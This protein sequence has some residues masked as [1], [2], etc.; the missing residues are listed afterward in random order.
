M[1]ESFKYLYFFENYKMFIL[2]ICRT[3]LGESADKSER[4]KWLIV[5]KNTQKI[6][7]LTFRSMDS[8]ALSQ[9]RFFKEGYLS[10]DSQKAVFI[11]ES[12]SV[13]HILESIALD[14]ICDKLDAA[15]F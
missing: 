4:Y 11:F 12:S 7:T 14:D 6:T 15:I 2:E 8:S 9:E 13:Q 5:D 3:D 1:F 10:F